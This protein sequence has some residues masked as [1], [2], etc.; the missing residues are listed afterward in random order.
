VITVSEE[1]MPI[2]ENASEKGDLFVTIKVVF[3]RT[4]TAQQKAQVTAL[5]ADWVWDQ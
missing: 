2:P 3:P 4:M 5:T 1:G